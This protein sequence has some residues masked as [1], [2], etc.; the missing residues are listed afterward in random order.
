M[1]AQTGERARGV[2]KRFGIEGKGAVK[3]KGNVRDK[4]L[5]NGIGHPHAC[6]IFTRVVT[7]VKVEAEEG[8]GAV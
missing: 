2:Y 1:E 4:R 7:Y 6:H 5:E 8:G 3:G